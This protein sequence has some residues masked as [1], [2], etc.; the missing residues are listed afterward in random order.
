MLGFSFLYKL[1]FERIEEAKRY[2][3]KNLAKGF[4]EFSAA[5]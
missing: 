2:I 4:I 3:V 1:I 5:A